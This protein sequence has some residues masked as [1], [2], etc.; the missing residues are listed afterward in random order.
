LNDVGMSA[1]PPTPDV[2]FDA[3]NRRFGPARDIGTVP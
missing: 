1:S 2:W 3:A